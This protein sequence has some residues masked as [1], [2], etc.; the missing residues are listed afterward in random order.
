MK[1][2]N[3][4]AI[5]ASLQ[6]LQLRN[7][8]YQFPRNQF[9]PFIL[10]FRLLLHHIPPANVDKVSPGIGLQYA[11]IFRASLSVMQISEN[12]FTCGNFERIN[13]N[14]NKRKKLARQPS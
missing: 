8:L 13:R 4:K 2:Q 3:L 9:V 10:R 14:E 5:G 1:L 6:K 11:Y 7:Q 12:L